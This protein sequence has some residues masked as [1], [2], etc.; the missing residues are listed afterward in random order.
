MVPVLGPVIGIA[1]THRDSEDQSTRRTADPGARATPP[2]FRWESA[3][4]RR[5]RAPRLNSGAC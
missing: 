1:V 3:R 2:G 4:Q 5:C